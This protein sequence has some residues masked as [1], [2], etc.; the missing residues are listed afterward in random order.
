MKFRIETL[1]TL[2]IVLGT[3]TNASSANEIQPEQTIDFSRDVMP[4][5][6]KA[7]CNQGKCHG[8]FQGRG[9][10]RL[11]LLGFDAPFDYDALVRQSRGR[12][13]FPAA[14]EQ[15]LILRKPTG[16]VPHGGGTILSSD[17]AAYQILL[18]WIEQGL[19]APAAD[20]PTVT[21][22][23]VEP[24][25]IR[26]LP[27]EQTRLKVTAQWTDGTTRDV[28]DWVL[29]EIR[30]ELIAKV[31]EDGT[32]HAESSGRTAITLQYLGQVAAVTVTVPV[33][34]AASDFAWEPVNEIDRLVA[35]EWKKVGYQPAPQSTDAEFFR[36]IHLD[37]TG[38]LPQPDEVRA[39]LASGE[40]DKRAKLIEQLLERPEYV[41]FWSLKWG[42]LLRVHR[43]YF[44][45]KGLANYAGWV[46]RNLRENRGVD[47]V[48]REL[49]TAKGNLYTNG[50]VAF[51]LTDTTPENFTETTAQV[52]LGMRMHCARCHHHP[53]EV[54]SQEDYYGLAAFFTRFEVKDNG[55]GGRFGGA[56]ILRT[57]DTPNKKMRL[58]MDVPPQIF[59]REL[60]KNEL[61]GDVRQVLADWITSPDNPYFAQS[62]TNRYWSY[63]MGR[64]LVHPVDDFRDTNPPSHPALLNY[65]TREFVEHDF[66]V[67]HLIRLICN[68]RTYQ[69]ACE[70][71]PERDA[72]GIF[73]THRTLQRMSAEV[74]LDAV[75]LATGTSEQ[76]EGLPPGTRAIA[77]PDPSIPSYFLRTFGRSE[78]AN[79]CECARSADP[80]LSQA[81]HLINGDPLET[82]VR[83]SSGRL[84]K[85]LASQKSNTEIVE[86]LFLATYSRFPTEAESHT[87]VTLVE[88][89]A[90]RREGFEDLLWTL[91]NSNWFV[92]NH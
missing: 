13:I 68:S 64:G 22:L 17:A 70:A 77:L 43:R 47:D 23:T 73:Y 12:R 84:T 50:P 54:W 20:D 35:A 71:Q 6:T 63:F 24:A 49:L 53:Y 57:T 14:P 19:P 28:T 25:E 48:V 72:D 36:R 81:L 61:A 90:D 26:L 4:A 60:S 39:F 16:Q 1:A 32:V 46:R 37:L 86:E 65:L 33:S 52:F 51:Y 34:E 89:A 31:D 78:R 56:M 76:F 42:D 9:G 2:A 8:S 91:L 85:L 80:D 11:S 92:F 15:S 29:F 38:T 10:F 69:L 88:E 67:K 27:G 87:A 7:G 74:L 30:H 75:N 58:A 55:G 79:P 3:F 82:K 44:G 18:N 40:P 45:S 66:D 21:S 59:G 83:D 41:D 62:F 5:L